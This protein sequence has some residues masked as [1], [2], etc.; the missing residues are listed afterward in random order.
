MT[1]RTALNFSYFW[2]TGQFIFTDSFETPC[3]SNGRLVDLGD[4]GK[5]YGLPAS[6]AVF[7]EK[8]KELGN[9]YFQRKEFDRAI[10]VYKQ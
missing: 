7:S 2:N 5:R 10:Q 6:S 4:Y 1:Y 9:Y 8:K 3:R